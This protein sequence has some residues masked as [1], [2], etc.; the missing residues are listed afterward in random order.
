MRFL[1]RMLFRPRPRDDLRSALVEQLEANR[2]AEFARPVRGATPRYF[3]EATS[4]F[5]QH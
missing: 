1:L 4:G 2:A 5:V 3:D